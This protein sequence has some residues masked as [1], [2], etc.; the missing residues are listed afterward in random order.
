MS[1]LNPHQFGEQETLFDAP[2][3]Q[4]QRGTFDGNPH[5]RLYRAVGVHEDSVGVYRYEGGFGYETPPD[6][7]ERI[8]AN[9]S[10][11]H[12]DSGHDTQ[13]GIH[14]QH[15]LPTAEDWGNDLRQYGAGIHGDK[16][17]PVVIEADH[18]GKEHVI[19]RDTAYHQGRYREE[20]TPPEGMDVNGPTW[21]RNKAT[22]AAK[23]W[24]LIHDTVGPH[25]MDAGMSPEVPVR[26]GAP[27]RV[28]AIHLPDPEETGKYIR[29]PV[30]FR[31]YA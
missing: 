22:G 7:H 2:L 18:P 19:S 13:M 15:D 29:H 23:D 9:V 14:W 30:Q 4:P 1:E 12:K 24:A 27:M 26:P 8:L 28:H 10:R 17:F 6:F 3:G 11:K 31:G 20:A 5:A 16:T 25:E 21:K